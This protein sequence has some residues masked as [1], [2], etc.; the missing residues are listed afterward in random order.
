VPQADGQ[1]LEYLLE[2]NIEQPAVPKSPK[3]EVITTSS[4]YVVRPGDT[5]GSIAKQF[6]TT[7]QELWALNRSSIPNPN[8][9]YIGQ[10]IK[11]SG[12]IEQVPQLSR[13]EKIHK[14]AQFM[15]K[16]AGLRYEDRISL[17]SA[18]YMYQTSIQS[19]GLRLLNNQRYLMNA[20]Y[21]LTRQYEIW[22]LS[23]AIVDLCT[24]PTEFY[25][26]V[27]LAWQESHFV[28]RVGHHDERGFFQVL[29]IT[30]KQHYQLDNISLLNTLF[31]IENDPYLATQVSLDLLRAY[32]YDFRIWNHDEAYQFHLNNKIYSFKYEWNKK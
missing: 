29:P 16:K 5:L 6:G 14:L 10:R 1:E 13:E 8:L 28:N 3:I 24:D 30:I 9:I 15:F 19:S 23:E 21:P 18:I 32:K 4:E 22:L 12:P 31:N 26:I 20:L 11:V 2:Y 27:G 7:W 25:M 17:E